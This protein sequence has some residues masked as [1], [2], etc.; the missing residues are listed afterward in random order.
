VTEI[1][2]RIADTLV[3]RQIIRL[4]PAFR[5]PAMS[6]VETPNVETPTASAPNVDTPRRQA[7]QGARPKW[8]HLVVSP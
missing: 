3:P 8:E 5:R 7:R 4:T 1:V 6:S 2:R